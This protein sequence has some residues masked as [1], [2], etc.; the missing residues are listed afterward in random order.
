[1]LRRQSN[2]ISDI[3]FTL[4]MCILCAFIGYHSASNDKINKVQFLF[5]Q[6]NENYNTFQLSIRT[7]HCDYKKKTCYMDYEL[8]KNYIKSTILIEDYK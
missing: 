6:K 5:D 4:V 2:P 8:L 3:I 7:E 1:M